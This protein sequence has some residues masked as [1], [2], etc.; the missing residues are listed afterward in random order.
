MLH[1]FPAKI[2]LSAFIMIFIGGLGGIVTASSIDSWYSTLNKP[3]GTPP[4]W[5]F[6]PVWTTLYL[7]IGIAFALIWHQHQ[8]Q[9]GKTRLTLFFALQLILNLAWTPVFFGARQITAALVVIILLWI[10]ILFTIR[11]LA[12]FSKTAALLLVPYLLWVSYASYLN[13]GYTFLN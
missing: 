10:S 12:K 13:A 2:T 9:L 1:S 4:N 7:L 5:L 6:G 11:E 8:A 3:P